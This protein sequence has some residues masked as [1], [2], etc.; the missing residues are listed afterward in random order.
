MNYLIFIILDLIILKE[1][2]KIITKFIIY[3]HIE[4]INIYKYNY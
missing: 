3:K 1:I 4:D 2:L